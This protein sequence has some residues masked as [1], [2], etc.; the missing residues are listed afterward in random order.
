MAAQLKRW[1][2]WKNIALAIE[3]VAK[4]HTFNFDKLF[5]SVSTIE[6]IELGTIE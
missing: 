3:I 1:K 6:S 2:G 5:H 4:H